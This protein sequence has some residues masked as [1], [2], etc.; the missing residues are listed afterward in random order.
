MAPVGTWQGDGYPSLFPLF[1]YLFST[2]LSIPLSITMSICPV[3]SPLESHII[4]MDTL[5]LSS[6]HLTLSFSIPT[7]F[8]HLSIHLAI[9]P[10]TN[11]FIAVEIFLLF[12][13]FFPFLPSI[14]TFFHHPS[15]R[16]EKKSVPPYI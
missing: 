15:V 7:L 12:S 13:L 16:L 2:H 14:L 5:L 4:Y 8:C 1:F 10:P 11:P 9:H 6:F 3:H